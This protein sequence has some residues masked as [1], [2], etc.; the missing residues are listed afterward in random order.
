MTY[1]VYYDLYFYFTI[2]FSK[3]PQFLQRRSKL[4]FMK[5]LKNWCDI[6]K[7]I[8]RRKK[9]RF[10]RFHGKN[11][12]LQQNI[13]EINHFEWIEIETIQKYNILHHGNLKFMVQISRESMNDDKYKPLFLIISYKASSC[14]H[15]KHK[16]K[17]CMLLFVEYK[18]VEQRKQDRK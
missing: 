15:D 13:E 17:N 18:S 4:F 1:F 3:G 6:L 11:L 5:R 7:L 10:K 2:S 9:S 16:S 12:H 14:D 8:K